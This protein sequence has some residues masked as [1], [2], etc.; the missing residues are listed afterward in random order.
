MFLCELRNY[1]LNVELELPFAVL[2]LLWRQLGYD[3]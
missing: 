2:L 3:E 1:S